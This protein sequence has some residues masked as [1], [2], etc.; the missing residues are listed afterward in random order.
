MNPAFVLLLYFIGKKNKYSHLYN[1]ILF[2][3]KNSAV[4]PQ[5]FAHQYAII[6]Q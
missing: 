5:A 3:K 2:S 4:I 6:I 1:T